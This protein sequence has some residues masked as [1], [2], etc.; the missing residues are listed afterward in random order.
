MDSKNRKIG[1]KEETKVTLTCPAC[2][3]PRPD[4]GAVDGDSSDAGEFCACPLQASNEKEYP[5]LPSENSMESAAPPPADIS[6]SDPD[7]KFTVVEKLGEGGMATVFKV[8]DSGQREMAMKVMNTDVAS[9]KVAVKRFVKEVSIVS[10]LT[11]PN[12]AQVY[13]CFTPD[14]G[15]PYM[16]MEYVDGVTLAEIIKH[17]HH[18]NQTRAI[19]ICVQV[20]EALQ[21]A[22]SKHIIHR[23]LKPSNIIVCE[24][25]D[26]SD[27]V[28]LVDFGIAKSAPAH[29]G[30]TELT[31]K[32]EVFG[33]PFCM[34]PEQCK[35]L[36]TDARSDIYSL[37]CVM[38]EALTGE[39]VF[40][41]DNSIQILLHHVNTPIKSAKEKLRSRGVSS[42]LCAVI[43]R[44]LA[45]K[46]SGRYQ[47][48]AE[49][50]TDFERLRQHK[51]PSIV[52][53][54][55]FMVAAGVV[56]SVAIVMLTVL[57]VRG[58]FAPQ[59]SYGTSGY[60]T[61]SKSPD[62][63]PELPTQ[64][65]WT[66]PKPNS[67]DPEAWFDRVKRA[68][69]EGFMGRTIQMQLS[70]A[71]RRYRME[72]MN[73]IY[74]DSQAVLLSMGPRIIPSLVKHLNDGSRVS[75]LCADLLVS[76]GKP[77]VEP[78]TDLL[79][80]TVGSTNCEQAELVL[81]RLAPLST[82]SVLKLIQ[83]SDQEQRRAGAILLAA[84]LLPLR[85]DLSTRIQFQD[86]QDQIFRTHGFL[87]VRHGSRSQQYQQD[88][89]LEPSQVDI[90]KGALANEEDANIRANLTVV[91]AELSSQNQE[92]AP[93]LTKLLK[94]DRSA[95]VRANAVTGLG[96]IVS[97]QSN[98]ADKGVVQSI[99][100]SLKHDPDSHVRIACIDTLQANIAK[101]PY[102]VPQL[103]EATHDSLDAVHQKAL[104]ALCQL[105]PE[106]PECQSAVDE[107]FKESDQATVQAA[108]QAVSRLGREGG[109]RYVPA[110]VKALNG[111]TA[112]AAAQTLR[113][114]GE[115]VAPQAV[116][117]MISALESNRWP[118]KMQII[119]A[120]PAMGPQAKKAIPE[121]QRIIDSNEGD[122]RAVRSQATR[123]LEQLK[124]M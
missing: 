38:V 83:S 84:A 76:F 87:N 1:Q 85:P 86:T 50:L 51:T 79:R 117:A 36:E 122:D 78:V 111:R 92:I 10:N 2:G 20:C 30:I 103:K 106:H 73:R 91:L 107:A 89:G 80:R 104:Q 67:D 60:I 124:S 58:L 12:I 31:Q 41:G 19:D 70:P 52:Q 57:A 88:A 93:L 123:A 94:N 53:K 21:H 40:K 8:R 120:L 90:V 22:H 47:S 114:L 6:A 66:I 46:P 29:G 71:E 74:Q 68:E 99:L 69:E 32:G 7:T 64:A 82:P 119:D 54:K 27:S 33:S 62:Q 18:L 49:V 97:M 98:E 13:G 65:T 112:T 75:N 35:G 95:I 42:Q 81:T 5:A 11:H 116:P 77:S 48:V 72:E 55:R 28:K 101:A 44:M 39:T 34:S 113:S 43:D 121:L 45:K 14:D 105:Y 16:M 63:L 23:D 15:N 59:V 115:A 61:Q 110:L 118:E 102:I 4:L 109:S 56:S 108:I 25:T 37:G 9:S 100:A 26:G 17:E 96:V 3:K 24:N